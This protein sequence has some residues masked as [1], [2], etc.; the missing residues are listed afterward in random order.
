MMIQRRI[1]IIDD[2]EMNR[3]T[4]RQMLCNDY[5][6]LE[7][8]SGPAGLQILMKNAED[9]AAVLLD[10]VMPDV[11]GY[12]VLAQ[13]RSNHVLCKIPVIVTTGNADENSEV[14]A[15]SL[16]ANDYITKPYNPSIIKHR[17]RNTINQRENSAVLNA[18]NTDPLTG[19]Y[20][21]I[22]FFHEVEEK[23]SMREP[24]YYV[25]AC[26]D[27]DGFKV[28]NDQY[29]NERGDQVL[30]LIA[31]VFRDGFEPI[32]GICSRISADNFAILYPQSFQDSQEIIEIRRKAAV[33]DGSMLPLSFSIGHYIVD[34][35]FLSPSTM[36]DRACIAK[37][38]IKGR[39]DTHI[40][41]YNEAMR[42]RILMQQEIISEM[43]SAL[44]GR[45]FEIWLQPQY[46]H[47]S[48]ALI[49]AEALVRWRHPKRG[50][51]PPGD[52]IPLFEK[53]GFVYEVDKYVWEQSC[54]L[55][56]KWLDAGLQ[57]TPLSV[58]VSRYDILRDD[59]IDVIIGLVEKYNIPVDLLRLE[60][61]ESAFAKAGERIISVVK[62]L[63][64][65][66]F[67]IEIDDFGSGYSS[68]NTLKSVP[69]D[70]VKLDMRFLEGENNSS[71]GGNI[72]E[73]IV[74]MAKWLGMA[75]IAEGV[76][77]IEQANFL[78]SIG[79]NY[80]QGYFYARPMPMDEFEIMAAKE[81]KELKLRSMET[82]VTLDSNAFWD[83]NSIETLIFNSFVC[84]AFIFEYYK[85]DIE[86]L[87]VNAKYAEIFGGKG[88]PTDKVMDIVWEDYAD[89]KSIKRAHM[90][91]QKAIDTGKEVSDEMKLVG[92]RGEGKETYLRVVMRVIARADERYMFYCMIEDLTS[93][94]KAELKEIEISTQMSAIMKN[95]NGGV[96]VV[97]I[98]ED[99]TVEYVYANEQYYQQLGY[100][101]EQFRQEVS[102][103]FDLIHP[104][105]REQVLKQ[106]KEGSIQGK[107]Y[108]I[109]YRAFKRD[110]SIVWLQSSI[111]IAVYP[112][113]E[114]PVQIAVAN[115]ITSQRN[116]AQKEREIS[117][118]IRLLNQSMDHIMN[119]SPGGFSLM[120]IF[121]D[122]S[123]QAEYINKG[124]CNMLGMT[125]E[126]IMQHYR[127]DATW[128]IHPEDKEDVRRQVAQIFRNQGTYNIKCRLQH[129]DGSY[130]SCMVFGR[131]SVTT[132]RQVFLD[133]F[134]T[135]IT[136]QLEQNEIERKKCEHFLEINNH[137]MELASQNAH[138]S[139]W[140]YDITNRT[141]RRDPYD[142]SERL[143]YPSPAENVPEIF[144]GTGDV[145]P[146][147]E[148][149][150]M[151]MY[152][153]LWQGKERS[154]CTVRLLNRNTGQYEWQRIAYARLGDVGLGADLA[155]ACSV[156]VDIE[157]ENKHYES[158][159]KEHLV[160]EAV[161]NEEIESVT[162]IDVNSKKARLIQLKNSQ[163]LL[164]ADEDFSVDEE[165]ERIINKHI[166]E[167][168]RENCRK[169]FSIEGLKDVLER[170]AIGKITFRILQQDGKL[171]CKKC[172]AFYLGEQRK[173]IV[174]IRRDITDL[175]Q[176]EQLQKTNLKRAIREANAANRAKSEFLSNMSHDMRTPLNAVLTFSNDELTRE[177]TLQQAQDYL[178]KI[179]S[180]GEYLL[181]IIN[182]VLDMS[183]IEQNKMML[184]SER[185]CL[186]DFLNIINTVIGKTC[187]MKNIE[188]VVDS[189][190]IDSSDILTD[191]TRF[192]QIFINLLSNAV[193]FTPEGGKVELILE[194][195]AVL[196]G[197]KKKLKRFTIRDNGIGMSEGF[198]PH[199]FESFQQEYR[200]GIMEK[201]QGTGLG[202]AIV[203]EIVE[204][205]KGTIQ[206]ES[207][208]N[209]G[210]TFIIEMPVEVLAP[211]A[212][213]QEE[214]EEELF[215]RP[216][217]LLCEDNEINTEITRALLEKKGCMV[218]CV[219]NGQE[220]LEKYKLEKAGYYNVILMDIRMP[221]MNGLE[222][223]KAIRKTG[224]EDAE[225]IPIIAM[226][227]DAFDEDKI[228]SLK[229]GMNA[230]LSKPIQPKQLY[231]TLKSFLK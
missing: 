117:E 143:G 105:D 87:R 106:T 20:T 198:L 172:R 88:M 222:A 213:E 38:S 192:N 216:R 55:L 74:R 231:R 189:S 14:K 179:H 167:A 36:Y 186:Q 141:I 183:K 19:L 206:L 118:K 107:S 180:A 124:F 15:L 196:E 147:D 131:A 165:Y 83:T 82:L 10:L 217:I 61:T 200:P 166:I 126:E 171:H 185:Y 176:E 2:Y 37:A 24:G 94:R 194:N 5:E 159:K 1:L 153:E 138:I 110:G 29:G 52:F 195:I 139:F 62:E 12:E 208:I 199:A 177:A 57:P 150:F 84:G 73:A 45:Q 95:M 151:T 46:S 218:D 109:I 32:G 223:A 108:T 33:Q 85:G 26:F 128:G 190:K 115:D 161:I 162:L 104:E 98:A 50:I 35:V 220:G 22:A 93:Q 130:I 25:M 68:L 39:Y 103:P 17:I 146:E 11:D 81:D 101:R 40:A 201:N 47:G 123:M 204:L 228:V 140:L 112:G 96:T 53:N 209:K 21:R 210:T 135:N 132:S 149:K 51:V 111:S 31:D 65:L 66:R 116:M 69:A 48:G 78:K 178:K 226:T 7:A 67:I 34:D 76:E 42:N 86:I 202:L 63:K 203:K 181:S 79:C 137:I 163:G 16:G 144:I 75:V 214:S 157:Q 27:I 8:D 4:L 205:M 133:V 156:N 18:I 197:G 122:G 160:R 155:V 54:I 224:R 174:L 134:Y 229:A 119:D 90:I 9:I 114:K 191:K 59:I 64:K 212:A 28:I 136:E 158:I 72:L 164:R 215:D 207:E 193:K 99:N 70:V 227:A 168:D 30:Q 3:S 41:Q 142:S 89:E 170:D 44:E 92:L 129:K 169:F 187:R 97:T 56:R 145:F 80:Q 211:V 125:E 219:A 152:E 127:E 184:F 121:A 113:Y 77:T 154:Q 49:G 175:Y 182:D 148:E 173:E 23:I 43:K 230:H 225:K 102:S 221:V 58:N 6:V 71:R 60:I 91:M 13:I 188:F 120:H 100:T